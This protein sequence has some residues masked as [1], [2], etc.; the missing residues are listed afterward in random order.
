MNDLCSIKRA[1]EKSAICLSDQDRR[2][3][4]F[5]SLIWLDVS[6]ALDPKSEHFAR[7]FFFKVTKNQIPEFPLIDVA[8]FPS[9][10]GI[11][12]CLFLELVT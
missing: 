5:V 10:N 4:L 6:N 8:C 7:P 11:M 1:G 12:R 3:E 9:R 2:Q